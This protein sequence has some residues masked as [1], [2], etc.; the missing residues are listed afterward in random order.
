[1]AI[2]TR[3]RAG[4]SP[5][6]ALSAQRLKN[7]DWAADGRLI[8]EATE[9][10]PDEASSN[11]WE[12][13]TDPH[14]GRARSVP[15]KI[16]NWSGISFHGFNVAADGKRINLVKTRWSSAVYI[17]ELWTRGRRLDTVRRLTL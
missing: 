3:D 10:Y 14:T 4:G 17:G 8:Y 2:E 13:D 7:L 5:V 6:V 1:M 9:P 12:I 15:R 11:L 16:T